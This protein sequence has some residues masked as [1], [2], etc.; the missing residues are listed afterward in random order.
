M[1]GIHIVGL[2]HARRQLEEAIVW[3]AKYPHLY[4]CLPLAETGVLLFGPPGT[5]KS[6]C[7]RRMSSLVHNKLVNLSLTDAVRG[8]VG[9]GEKAIVA[10]FAE[11]KLLS[12]SIVF[13]DEFQ[14]I[15]TA[16]SNSLSAT[17]AGCF[18]DIAVWN[19]HASAGL[20]IVIAATN[21]P[22]LIDQSFLRPGRFDRVVFVGPLEEVARKEMLLASFPPPLVS[23][24]R[25][26]TIVSKTQRFSG[27]D[28]GM[29]IRKLQM[30]LEEEEKEV[31]HVLQDEE[32][33]WW[34]EG[35]LGVTATCSEIELKAFKQ[36][37][38]DR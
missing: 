16:G 14:A 38:R 10:A 15:F 11:A 27:A 33:P 21:E 4:A 2:A 28:M 25:I 37:E 18:D 30:R 36:W 26:K 32:E 1:K 13:I 20:V 5:G 31:G 22:W 19:R 9:T 17:L 6:L 8:E 34:Q 23:E 7:A 3:P 24:E 12:P 29:L 35:F